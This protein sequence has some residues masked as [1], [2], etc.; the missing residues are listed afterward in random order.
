STDFFKGEYYV[1]L[2][3][4]WATHPRL[5]QRRSFRNWYQ[6]GYGFAFITFRLCRSA[7]SP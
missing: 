5:A 4:S 2:G 6:A 3:A 1:V 7:S